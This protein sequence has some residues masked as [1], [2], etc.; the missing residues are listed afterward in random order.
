MNNALV[1]RTLYRNEEAVGLIN[2]HYL[3]HT[4]DSLM[5]FETEEIAEKFLTK[6][7]IDLDHVQIVNFNTEKVPE[8]YPYTHPIRDIPVY[9]KVKR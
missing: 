1:V 9:G 2:Y 4:D 5:K 6:N 3:L 7:G 8:P